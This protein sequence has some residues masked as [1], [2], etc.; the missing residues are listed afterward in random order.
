ML[1]A[2]AGLFGA[3]SGCPLYRPLMALDGGRSTGPTGQDTP[4]GHGLWVLLWED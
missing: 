4:Q 1:A 3:E 2:E